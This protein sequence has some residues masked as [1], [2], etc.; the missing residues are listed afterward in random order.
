M[1]VKPSLTRFGSFREVTRGG[2][3]A[4]AIDSAGGIWD[5]FLHTEPTTS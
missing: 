5:T 4:W 2:D 1:Y 3:W